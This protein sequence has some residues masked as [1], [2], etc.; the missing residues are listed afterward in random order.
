MS[1][2]QQIFAYN[3]GAPISGTTQVGDIAIIENEAN[4]YPGLG[5][6]TWWGGPDES[7]GYVIATPVSGNTQPTPLFSGAPSGQMSCSTIYKGPNINLSNNNQTAF[8]QFGYQMSVLTNTSID[9][10]DRVMFSVLSTSLEPATLPQSRFIGVGKTTM[11]YQGNPYGGYPGND[12]QS[13]GFN[14]IGEYY[15]NGSVV[16]SGLPTFTEGD[17]IDIAIAHGQYWFIRVNGGNW[18]NNPAANP[19]TL[20]GGLTMNGLTNYYPALCPGYEGT[21]TIQ[22]TSTYGVP[23]GYT[24]LGTNITAS[25]RFLGTKNMTNPFNEST[26]VELTNIS[27]NQSFSNGNDAS[28]WLT[29]NGYWN[30]WVSNG[31]ILFPTGT[32]SYVR[33]STPLTL[34]L[35]NLT[36]EGW[37]YMTSNPATNRFVLVGGGGNRGISI[38]N[39]LYGSAN[40]TT[41][42]I[43]YESAGD[44]QF[45]VPTM[46]AN[47]WYHIAVSRDASNSMSLWL[48]GVRAGNPANLSFNFISNNYSIGAWP[49]QG[50][51]SNDVYISN[52]RITTTNVYNVASPTIT[53][54]TAPLTNIAGTQL[55]M[56]TKFGAT[57]LVDSSS[58]NITMVD[59]G[60]PSS[61]NYEPFTPVPLPTPTPTVT[62]TPTPTTTSTPTPSVTTTSTPTLTPTKTLTPTPTSTSGGGG[63]DGWFFYTP[64]GPIQGPP[65]S[66]GNTIFVLNGNSSFNPNFTGASITIYFNVYTQGG[67]DYATQFQSLAS[68]GGTF[69]MTQNGVSATYSGAN[70]TFN[71]SP[72][73]FI[74]F[75]ITNYNQLVSSAATPF[76]SGSPIT[77]TFNGVPVSTPTPTPTNTSTPVTA[78]PTPTNT[79]TP[80]VTPSITPTNTKTPTPTPTITPTNTVTPTITPSST[81]APGQIIV[82]AGGVNALSYSYDG[83]NWV[84]S[85]NG[86][87]FVS[88]PAPAVASSP[89]TFVAGGPNGSTARLIYS[90]NGI[91]WSA[92]TNGNTLFNSVN[93]IAYGGGKFVAVGINT[94]ALAGIAYSTDGITWT[95]SNSVTGIFGSVPLSVAYNG[96][97]WVA[98]AQPGG[99]ANPKNTIAYSDDGITWTASAN[100]TSI[101]TSSGRG[102][103]WGGD[104]WVAVGTGTN[105][106]A[107]STDGITWSATTNGNTIITGTGYGVRYNGSQWVAVGQGT[108]SIAY[109]N[110]G[111]TWSASTNGN[112]IF[113]FQGYCITWDS[114]DSQWIAGGQGTNQLAISTDGITWSATTNGNTIMNDR[115]LALSTRN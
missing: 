104:K 22:N 15:Y 44:Y 87:T 67:T 108:N 34:G 85:S 69:T 75:N 16:D 83:D 70:T 115:V 99:G 19:A 94:S 32:N 52:V 79:V 6:L 50:M 21:M 58:N 111:L 11:N 55:L 51:Y 95:A 45:T 100:S 97:R 24:L 48:N 14:A 57:W 40:A 73:S 113:S 1:I 31:S 110:N 37:V 65:T 42:T 23:S 5:G 64:E 60:S 102:V 4:Y 68:T 92:S 28:T 59:N 56:N 109:S 47:V 80:T 82:A 3:T 10:N 43:D 18:N 71:Y 7:Q 90:N 78:T 72:N 17:I 112:T 74:G 76:I 62:S 36:V 61:S 63:G 12:T 101:F 107:Y 103:A 81:P 96:S 54:P 114:F 20:T 13:I 26:F 86:A 91:T 25:V 41:I 46:V 38:Y 93:G 27:F 105:R 2:I 35:G 77:L 29:S 39:G 33:A 84:N 30:S 53:V 89:T 9:N 8:Q 88:Q 98:T 106:M 49:T 66:S